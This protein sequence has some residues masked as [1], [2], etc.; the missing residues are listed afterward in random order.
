MSWVAG[1]ERFYAPKD[2]SCRFR[3]PSGGLVLHRVDPDLPVD[4][5]TFE[6][7]SHRLWQICDEM[8][9]TLRKVS[10]SP[11]A[12]EAADFATMIA[13]ESGAG[14]YMGPYVLNHAVVLEDII[15]WTLIHR[16]EN[17]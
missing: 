7:V 1:A 10:G 15:S 3:S 2:A 9:A 14:V 8:G 6:V 16:V 17:P 11:V 13:D 5:V 4:L 12:T